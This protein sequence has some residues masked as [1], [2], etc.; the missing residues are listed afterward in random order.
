[1]VST[2]TAP[3]LKSV[4]QPDLIQF[5]ISFRAYLD[6]VAEINSSRSTEEQIQP[7]LIKN[8]IEPSILSSLCILGKIS[9]ASVPNEATENAVQEWFEDRLK[10]APRDLAERMRS[11]LATVTYKICRADPEG[12]ALTFVLDVISALD[13]HNAAEVVKNGEICKNL[14]ERLVKKLEP[15]ELRERVKDAHEC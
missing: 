15:P 8:C 14:I 13:R 7:A 1:M 5:E 2:I 10:S 9:G 6:K 4:K 11:A 12:A 3:L